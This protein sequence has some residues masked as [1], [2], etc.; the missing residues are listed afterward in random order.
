MINLW[1]NMYLLINRI[2]H[3]TERKREMYDT[4]GK[5]GIK[6]QGSYG[7]A[8]G[9]PFFHDPFEIFRQ[10]F[11]GRDPFADFGETCFLYTISAFVLYVLKLNFIGLLF[12]SICEACAI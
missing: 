4:Y 6:D 11:G 3:C 7:A 2:Y 12:G 10:F 1:N 8:S 9:G 5:E